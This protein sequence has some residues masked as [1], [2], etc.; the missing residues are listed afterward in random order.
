MKMTNEKRLNE[1]FQNDC[2]TARR[3]HC[4]IKHKCA[5]YVSCSC[6]EQGLRMGIRLTN[7]MSEKIIRMNNGINSME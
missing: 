7:E 5:I 1:E 2:N 6:F 4:K 3:G